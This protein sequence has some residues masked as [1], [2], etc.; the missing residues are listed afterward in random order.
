[1][2]SR[3]AYDPFDI[4]RKDDD[5][6]KSSIISRSSVRPLHHQRE[7]AD[8]IAAREELD[9]ILQQQDEIECRKKEIHDRLAR[10]THEN[11]GLEETMLRRASN[12]HHR[13]V[14]KSLCFLHEYQIRY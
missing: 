4:E 1:M 13:E 11:Q 9:N 7:P 14:I 6:E 8:V 3:F 12:E 5:D 2:K 10:Q